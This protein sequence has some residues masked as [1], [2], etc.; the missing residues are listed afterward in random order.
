MVRS[1]HSSW[2]CD[3]PNYRW[4]VER[5]RD[6]VYIDRVVVA[7]RARQGRLATALYQDLF[8]CAKA[9]GIAAVSCEFDTDPP[10]EASR[11]F[12]QRFG[13]LEV[14]T[15]RIRGGSKAVSLQMLRLL[16]EAFV[17]E[18]WSSDQPRNSR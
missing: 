4:F 6:F 14:G 2:H 8:R 5:Y 15:Q 12:H 7:S 3:S 11:R 13:F 10:N 16:P 1:R 17:S 18:S 9:S